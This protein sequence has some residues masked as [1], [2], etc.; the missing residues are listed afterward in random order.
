MKRCAYKKSLRIF[1]ILLP[2][3]STMS[4]S[5]KGTFQKEPK[6]RIFNYFHFVSYSVNHGTQGASRTSLRIFIIFI[7]LPN[8]STMAH[9]KNSTFHIQGLIPKSAHF[10]R[11]IFQKQHIYVQGYIPNRAFFKMSIF[12]KRHI[13]HFGPHNEKVCNKDKFMECAV[14]GLCSF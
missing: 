14:F 5:K 1:I 6:L 9:S 7:L 8:Q 13:L 2:N 11:S 12:Q 10:N 3:Q 4:H